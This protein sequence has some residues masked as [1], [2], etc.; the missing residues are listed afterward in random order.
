MTRIFNKLTQEKLSEI[1]LD[2]A[3]KN[4]V[5]LGHVLILHAKVKSLEC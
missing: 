5:D 1:A 2:I 4:F 3:K